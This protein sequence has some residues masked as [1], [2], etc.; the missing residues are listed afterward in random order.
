M[1]LKSLTALWDQQANEPIRSELSDGLTA[2]IAAVASW[3][4]HGRNKL[5]VVAAAQGSVLAW[6]ISLGG[7][8]EL[9][10]LWVTVAHIP[11][12]TATVTSTTV[13]VQDEKAYVLSADVQRLGTHDERYGSS[14]F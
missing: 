1:V 6:N 14:R 3:H 2:S 4:S 8:L 13:I 10:D 5:F 9:F 7:I 12:E 11:G